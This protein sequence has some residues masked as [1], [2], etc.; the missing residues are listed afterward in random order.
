MYIENIDKLFTNYDLSM[1][2]VFNK[3][4]FRSTGGNFTCGV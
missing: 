4:S 3:L 2:C 1:L